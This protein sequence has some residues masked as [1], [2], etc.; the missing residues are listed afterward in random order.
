MHVVG[1][2]IRIYHDAERSSERLITKHINDGLVRL[3]QVQNCGVRSSGM[4]C[5]IG[6]PTFRNI[7]HY[8]I[9][10]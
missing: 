3:N 6:I 1:F 2:I 8:S 7:L 9:Y 4:S 10:V 5:G